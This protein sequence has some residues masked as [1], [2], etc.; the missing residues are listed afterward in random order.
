MRYLVEIIREMEILTDENGNDYESPT[1]NVSH[2]VKF[3]TKARHT[4][5]G[6]EYIFL[7]SE[8]VLE[9]PTVTT[10]EDGE[11]VLIEGPDALVKAKYDEMV[12]DIYAE[13]VIV[14]GTSNDVS[15]SA[16]AATWEAMQKR[17]ANYVDVE[18]NLPDEDAVLAYAEAQ[19]G[20]ADTYG[21]FRLKRI[22]QYQA[23][24]A[25]ILEGE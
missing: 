16:F 20:E 10:D 21:I 19:L 6:G 14:F 4:P 8:T 22:A 2:K 11:L 17:P 15:A 1:G 3:S 7:E 23:E 5:R 18:L 12:A 13:M 9:S 25:A 24:K